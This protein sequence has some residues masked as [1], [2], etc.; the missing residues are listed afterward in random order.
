MRLSLIALLAIAAS[1]AS[2]IA[3]PCPACADSAAKSSAP[4]EEMHAT[5]QYTRSGHAER[6]DIYDAAGDPP[7]AP[8]IV[9]IHGGGWNSGGRR[10]MSFAAPFF[11]GQGYVF[12]SIDYRLDQTAPF[13]AQLEDCKCAIRFLRAHSEEYHI[14]PERIGVWGDSAGGNLAALLGVTGGVKTLDG[15]GGW[16]DQSS[17][18]QA[19]LDWYGPTDMRLKQMPTYNVFVG[20][21]LVQR[22]LNG[23]PADKP[24]IAAAASPVTYVAPG[25]PPFLIMHGANDAVVPVSQSQEFYDALKASGNQATLLIVPGAG[26]GGPEFETAPNMALIARFFADALKK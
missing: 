12:C 23:S 17:A 14:D 24:D 20:R 9:A 3:C 26:H 15:L 11:T 21:V 25:E 13:P 16:Q 7:R 6:M 19:V 18:V 10:D 4:R 8:A 22:Y 2:M 1:S 5:V